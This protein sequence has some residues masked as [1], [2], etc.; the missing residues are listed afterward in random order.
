MIQQRYID[1][2][3]LNHAK[4]SESHGAT[5]HHLGAGMLYYALTYMTR[6]RQCVCL[7]SGGGFVPRMM[8]QAQI[9]MGNGGITC[10]VDGDMG[11]WGRPD[12]L[13]PDSFFRQAFPE[14]AIIEDTT[15]NAVT[16]FKHIDY[17]H[18]DADHSRDGTLADLRAYFPK[19][20]VTGIITL[21]DI[22]SVT[23]ND[24]HPPSG[25][26]EAIEIFKTEAPVEVVNFWN[27]GAG[28][29]ILKRKRA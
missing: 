4:W 23:H 9:D 2:L 24:P 19:M 16:R 25:V 21:H 3:L 27:V 10:L 29:A 14:I 5:D 22:L 17:L 26:S 15:A 28:T 11:P 18:I 7:G 12:W 13:K 1:N 8:C 6:A 20:S